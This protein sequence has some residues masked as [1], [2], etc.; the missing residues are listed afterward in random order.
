[1]K[2]FCALAAVSALMF[3]PLAAHADDD[4]MKH[5]ISA[6]N[7]GAYQ[8]YGSKQTN[9]R[10]KDPN[11]QGGL[12]MQVSVAGGG[13]PWDATAQVDVNQ[14]ITK[15]DAIECYVWLKAKSDAGAPVTLHGRLQVNAAPYT[16]VAETDFDVTGEWTLYDLKTT[17]DQDYDK[18]K[19][20]FVVH[21][22]TGKQ[23]VDLGPAFV[24]N[25]TRT[26]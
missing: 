2:V 18:G 9:K 4:I 11:V 6:P 15:G 7:V 21:L 10:I 25:M 5:L 1:M 26:Y 13:N 12:E 22:N 3:A 24:L 23:V 17:A 14:K 8:I 19:L 16:A 20:V